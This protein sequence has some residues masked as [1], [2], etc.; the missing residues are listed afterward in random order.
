MG[1]KGSRLGK[2]VGGL[3]RPLALPLMPLH[4]LLSTMADRCGSLRSHIRDYA[5]PCVTLVWSK[6]LT[7]WLSSIPAVGSNCSWTSRKAELEGA[8]RD[9]GAHSPSLGSGEGFS[10][11]W[12]FL[13]LATRAAVSWMQR[14]VKKEIKT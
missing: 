1:S 12:T 9:S 8:L 2:Q 6:M 4:I 13:L 3:F 14:F 7:P 5:D 11:L 10:A